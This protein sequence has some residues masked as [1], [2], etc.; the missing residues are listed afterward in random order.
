MKVDVGI[1]LDKVEIVDECVFWYD[2]DMLCCYVSGVVCFG[3][4][5]CGM[6]FIDLECRGLL[7]LSDGMICYFYC[8][9]CVLL[10]FD[11]LDDEMCDNVCLLIDV[12]KYK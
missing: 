4:G 5:C 11:L 1:F 9:L 8:L 10:K 2:F 3:D 7:I 6:W 12:V